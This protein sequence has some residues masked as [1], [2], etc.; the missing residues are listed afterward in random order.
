MP[1]IGIDYS[2]RKAYIAVADREKVYNISSIDLK[3]TK[4]FLT[5]Y[6]NLLASLWFSYRINEIYIEQS[7]SREGKYAWVGLQMEHM[8]ALLEAGAILSK[9]TSFEI[10][11]VTPRSWRKKLMG[12]AKFADPKQA[13]VDWVLE[14][15]D[16]EVPVLGKTGRGK[17]PDH[18]FAEAICIAVSGIKADVALAEAA[19]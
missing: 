6:Q 16:F 7:W 9:A 17:K 3:D 14:N 13:A 8:K 11:F 18:N 5:T 12:T 1:N 19:L 4:S 10:N 2:A 15:L